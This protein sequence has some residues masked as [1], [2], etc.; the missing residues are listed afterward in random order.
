MTL[1]QAY[2]PVLSV[3]TNEQLQAS[4]KAMARLE[5]TWAQFKS[6]HYEA[7][8]ND[9]QRKMDIDYIDNKFKESAAIIA[10]GKNL[11]DAHQA[12]ESARETLL[13]MRSRNNI[14]YYIDNLTRFH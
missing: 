12:I 6:R 11:K 13:S 3:T 5:K 1:D 10:T 7:M 4:Q 2:S 9:A 8:P 14:S